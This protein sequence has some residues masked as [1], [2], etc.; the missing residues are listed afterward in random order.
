MQYFDESDDKFERI[1]KV[2]ADAFVA[3][4]VLTFFTVFAFS[5]LGR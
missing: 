4:I 3:C 1:G 5:L 2:I